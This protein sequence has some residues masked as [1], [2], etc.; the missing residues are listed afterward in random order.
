MISIIVCCDKNGVIGNGNKIPWHYKEDMKWFKEQ[1]M[2]NVVIMGKN[3]HN[4][5]PKGL[6]GRICFTL[7]KTLGKP[8]YGVRLPLKDQ[9]LTW[10]EYYKNTFDK[11]TFIIGGAQ[12][13]E[14]FEEDADRILLT[15][16]NKEFEGD[17]YF[18]ISNI[19]LNKKYNSS[20]IKVSGDLTFWE[21]IK[22]G[23]KNE[24]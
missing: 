24:N 5:I 20:I 14:L 3:T 9:A 4:S 19:K 8:L 6:P 21:Y 10:A 18:P 16:I 7:S 17:T 11:D 15:R 2:N 1:T 13:Y 22:K 12:I 23:D